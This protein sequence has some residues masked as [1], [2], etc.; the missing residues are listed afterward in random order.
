MCNVN[1]WLHSAQIASS[2]RT[3]QKQSKKK[4]GRKASKKRRSLERCALCKM[5]WIRLNVIRS[6]I[7]SFYRV[8]DKHICI[9]HTRVR[10]CA[11]YDAVAAA[12]FRYANKDCC[13][14]VCVMHI[15]RASSIHNKHTTRALS[16]ML[17]ML[18]WITFWIRRNWIH[19]SSHSIVIVILYIM[20]LFSLCVHDTWT[21]RIIYHCIVLQ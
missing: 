16:L 8:H 20:W 2:Q 14:C 5:T 21:K 7:I 13:V 6:N 12:R 17:V 3:E 18:Q 9:T 11:C 4:L 10:V 1:D 19:G 15:H